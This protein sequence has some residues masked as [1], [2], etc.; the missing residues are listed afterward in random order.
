MDPGIPAGDPTDVTDGLPE[1]VTGLWLALT[2]HLDATVNAIRLD[3]KLAASSLMALLITGIVVAALLLGLWFLGMGLIFVG[4][5]ALE[6]SK[7]VALLLIGAFQ[8]LLLFCCHRF[9]KRLLA[10]LN[11]QAT[12]AA[13]PGTVEG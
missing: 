1:L 7:V 10:N 3:I 11:F 12:R 2:R 6:V 8:L 5:A 9:S 4:L 13:M